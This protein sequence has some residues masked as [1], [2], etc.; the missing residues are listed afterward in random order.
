MSFQRFYHNKRGR[1]SEEGQS[2]VEF[3]LSLVV[4]LL[5]L[6][7]ILDLGRAYYMY[8]ALE[9]A[10]GE[11]A[12][13][14][15]INPSCPFG[16]DDEENSDPTITN[17]VGTV[18]LE[19]HNPNNA[20]YRA[21]HAGGGLV[22]WDDVDFSFEMPGA[23]NTLVIGDTVAITLR[24]DFIPITP[25]ITRLT[26]DNPITLSVTAAQLIVSEDHVN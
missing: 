18:G 22:N 19:C 5:I 25:I 4:I 11:A 23:A 13:Y 9:D 26:D 24:Y 10:A 14:I 7:G 1:T 20:K 17:A 16:P 6:A 8:V 12:L 21:T 15:S 2:L 3:A